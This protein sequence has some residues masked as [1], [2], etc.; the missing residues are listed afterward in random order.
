MKKDIKS[1]IKVG[2]LM[3]GPSSEHEVSLNTG[4][5]VLENLDKTKY[6]SVSI[7]ISK[8]G[9]WFLKGKPVNQ[10]EALRGHDVVFNALHGTF[11]EDGKV[12]G[13]LEHLGVRYTGSGI[14]GSAIAMDKFHSREIFKLAGLNTPKTLKIKKGEN[15]MARV[16]FFVNKIVKLPVVIKPCSNGSSVGVRIASDINEINVAVV[17]AFKLDRHVLVEEFIKGRELTCGVLDDF[18]LSGTGQTGALPV[19]EIIPV[20]NH[21]FFDYDAKYKPGHSNEIT[22]APLDS[23]MTQKVQDIAIK[24]HQVLGCRGY[25]RTDMILKNGNGT[26]YVLETNTLP[27]LTDTSLLPQSARIAGLTFSELL[28]K[29]IS[30][31]LV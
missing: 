24:A 5:N 21:G 29:I 26:I 28:D 30:S 8:T 22:P 9:R 12:Q 20:K 2:V 1:T 16:N 31:S 6:E 27:G 10:S 3:G 23:S 17:D 13:I 25:S 14:A 18:P 11:G 19:T 7:K 15:Y 4:K